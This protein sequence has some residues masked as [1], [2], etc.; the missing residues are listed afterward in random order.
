M[1][2]FL[3]VILAWAWHGMASFT[4]SK[5]ACLNS[6]DEGLEELWKENQR[7]ELEGAAHC[8]RQLLDE[9]A[10]LARNS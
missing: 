2:F 4:C 6:D 8:S 7:H 5:N 10:G 1:A 9:M 3:C